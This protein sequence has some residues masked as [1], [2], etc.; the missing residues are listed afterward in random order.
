MSCYNCNGTK[1]GD[2]CIIL[3]YEKE[4]EK[5]NLLVSKWQKDN[6]EKV[7]EFSREYRKTE[8]YKKKHKK[9][10][11]DNKDKI[12]KQAHWRY[13]RRRGWKK[14]KPVIEKKILLLNN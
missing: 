7:N 3:K 1:C 4:R 5:R 13:I 8:K 10:L 14:L 12:K 11:D 6:R 9:Y 2:V